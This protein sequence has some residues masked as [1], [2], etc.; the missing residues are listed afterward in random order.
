MKIR[1][2]SLPRS[3]STRR[4]RP[5]SYCTSEQRKDLQC[6]GSVYPNRLGF[7]KEKPQLVGGPASPS[8]SNVSSILN[9]STLNKDGQAPSRGPAKSTEHKIPRASETGSSSGVDSRPLRAMHQAVFCERCGQPMRREGAH[10]KCDRCGWLTHCCEGD[11]LMLAAAALRGGRLDTIA[12]Q[13]SP[14]PDST[15]R[16]RSRNSAS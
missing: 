16:T 8:A 15:P 4:P 2:D 10:D 12:P 7:G 1:S 13:P 3:P 9:F 5:E 11:I 14:P 6:G